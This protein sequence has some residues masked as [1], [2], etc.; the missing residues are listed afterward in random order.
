MNT[1]LSHFVSCY[2]NGFIT[3]LLND[4]CGNLYW[5]GGQIRWNYLYSPDFWQCWCVCLALAWKSWH[6]FPRC[7]I[8]IS[9]F[10]FLS[11][12]HH[13]LMTHWPSTMVTRPSYRSERQDY[14]NKMDSISHQN[15]LSFVVVISLN[16]TSLDQERRRTWFMFWAHNSL[17]TSIKS[18]GGPYRS[19]ILQRG[20]LCRIKVLWGR[21]IKYQQKQVALQTVI[22]S[23]WGPQAA[24]CRPQH[25]LIIPVSWFSSI[26]AFTEI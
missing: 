10:L 15:Y 8:Y 12:D 16:L 7:Q 3:K 9:L 21:D 13:W 17:G 25:L 18:E 22:T 19:G 20:A 14:L 24:R 4:K 26:P 5:S 23:V 1:L 11:T 2:K 6:F